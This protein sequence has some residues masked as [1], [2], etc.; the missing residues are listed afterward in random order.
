MSVSPTIDIFS[1]KL[2]TIE[3]NSLS[4]PIAIEN[5]EKNETIETL[6]LIDSAGGKFIDQN[7]ARNAGFKMQELKEPITARN[8][9]GTENKKGKITTFVDLKIT[10]NGRKETARLL[11]SGLGRQKIILG[12]PW[13]KE[14]NP[15][16]DWKNGKLNWRNP[17]SDIRRPLKIK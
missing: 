2:A 12:L 9:D 16:I 13:L 6:G 11:V 15:D 5:T 17:L 14:N 8:V 10:I 3:S 1:V 4:V 7:F